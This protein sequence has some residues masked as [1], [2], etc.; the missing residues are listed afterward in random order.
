MIISLEKSKS[1]IIRRIKDASE[2]EYNN[3]EGLSQYD[4][5]CWTRQKIQNFGF[6]FCYLTFSFGK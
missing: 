1:K 5:G 6:N 2:Y 3:V 4:P